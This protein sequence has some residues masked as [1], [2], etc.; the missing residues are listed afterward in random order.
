MGPGG[1]TGISTTKRSQ[2]AE[3]IV[4]WFADRGITRMR[5]E[6][7]LKRAHLRHADRARLAHGIEA[8]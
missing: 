3:R 5:I 4:C 2:L 1:G 7:S 6:E 8:A